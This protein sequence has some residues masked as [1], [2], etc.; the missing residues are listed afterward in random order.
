[1]SV[2][3][4]SDPPRDVSTM[5]PYKDGFHDILDERR[6]TSDMSFMTRTRSDVPQ[7]KHCIPRTPEEIKKHVLDSD[8]VKYTVERVYL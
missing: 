5:A 4:S 6:R 1:M 7:Y 3:F 2:I 8:R